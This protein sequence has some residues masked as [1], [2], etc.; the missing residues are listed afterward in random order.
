MKR[1]VK[2]PR[3]TFFAGVVLGGAVMGIFLAPP[4]VD[5][6]C[7]DSKKPV[8]PHVFASSPD[9]LVWDTTWTYCAPW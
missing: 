8:M 2:N 4:R 9:G 6:C 1:L 5:R 3:V 7:F